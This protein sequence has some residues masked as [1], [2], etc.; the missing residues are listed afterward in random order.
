MPYGQEIAGVLPTNETAQQIWM[1]GAEKMERKKMLEQEREIQL[2][3]QKRKEDID[4]QNWADQNFDMSKYGTDNLDNNAVI[5]ET[6][7]VLR[8]KSAMMYK[9]GA[10]LPQV[11]AAT[12]NA[13]NGLKSY[14]GAIKAG[15]AGID[16]EIG[17]MGQSESLDMNKA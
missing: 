5:Q 1:Q 15:N 10:Q 8:D 17:T 4:F 13:I 11:M 16:K 7:G 3:A 9:A 6:L 2:A 12:G 14:V